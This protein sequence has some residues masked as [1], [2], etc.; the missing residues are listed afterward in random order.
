MLDIPYAKADNLAINHN[1]IRMNKNKQSTD[2]LPKNIQI[3]LIGA[4]AGAFVVDT[5]HSILLLIR[6]YP[7]GIRPSQFTLMIFSTILLPLILFAAG[8]LFSKKSPSRFDRLFAATILTVIGYFIFRMVLV[9][10]RALALH[11]SLYQSVPILSEGMIVVPCIVA[12]LLY[13]GLLYTLRRHKRHTH[14]MHTLQRI[15]IPL[16][17]LAFVV[18][19]IFSINELV[20]RHIGSKNIMNLLTHQDLIT[21]TLLPIIFFAIAYLVVR[22]TNHL[23][24]LFV[25]ILYATIGIIINQTILIASNYSLQT[26]YITAASVGLYILVI[27]SLNWR[28][29]F[30]K[31]KK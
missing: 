25:V 13:A 16:A 15:M 28:N 2:Y 27:I 26:F 9:A 31:K 10:D 4:V 5:L 1:R 8:Y 21:T 20:G 23:T 18:E 12:L 14:G 11:T 3:T 19:A 7:H 22:N 6:I 24:R 30:N 29:I 17:L